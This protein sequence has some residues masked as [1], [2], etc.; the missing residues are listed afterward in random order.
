MHKSADL[1]FEI[2]AGVSDIWPSEMHEP[3]IFCMFFPYISR[4]PWE[5]RN[6]GLLVDV[7]RS[8]SWLRKSDHAVLGSVLSELFIQARSMDSL[9]FRKLSK[10]LSGFRSVAFPG[11]ESIQ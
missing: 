10:L 6:T 2:P 1:H 3:L 4:A 8:L 7:A 5:L 11:A 9:S